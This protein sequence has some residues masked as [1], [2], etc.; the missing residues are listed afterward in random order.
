MLQESAVICLST[1][2]TASPTRG[3]H[4]E[5][6]ECHQ[7]SAPAGFVSSFSPSVY[8][9]SYVESALLQLAHIRTTSVHHHAVRT[10]HLV[11]SPREPGRSS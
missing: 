11:I 1:P 5:P 9:H 2:C 7:T 3:A 6:Q 8:W 10:Q 4:L